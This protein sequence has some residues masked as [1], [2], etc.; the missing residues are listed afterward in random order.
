M[1]KRRRRWN[2]RILDVVAMFTIFTEAR[3]AFWNWMYLLRNDSMAA[4]MASQFAKFPADFSG[5]APRVH[6]C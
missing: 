2:V 4:I 6:G 3:Y 1:P 5:C